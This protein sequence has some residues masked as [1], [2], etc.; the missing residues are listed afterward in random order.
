MRQALRYADTGRKLTDPASAVHD[1]APSAPTARSPSSENTN[2]KLSKERA[3]GGYHVG[4]RFCR[5]SR[6]PVEEAQKVHK[7]AIVGLCTLEVT[8]RLRPRVPRADERY[9]IHGPPRYQPIH[10][11]VRDDASGRVG[12][13]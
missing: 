9:A 4:F 12:Q 6:H 13:G 2:E 11:H 5:G 10:A 7:P 8:L 3:Y 1:T